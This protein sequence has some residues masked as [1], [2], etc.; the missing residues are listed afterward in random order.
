MY[1]SSRLEIDWHPPVRA[2]TMRQHRTLRWFLFLVTSTSVLVL[3]QVVLG[4]VAQSLTLLSDVAHGVADVVSYGINYAME[5]RKSRSRRIEEQS[6]KSTNENEREWEVSADLWGCVLTTVMLVGA[7]VFSLVESLDR[8]YHAEEEE[9]FDEIGSSMLVF[10]IASTVVNVGS[11]V[12]FRFLDWRDRN[13]T[14]EERAEQVAEIPQPG[15]E[16]QVEGV[17]MMECSPCDSWYG[18]A[19][20]VLH[21]GCALGSCDTVL[22]S[23]PTSTTGPRVIGVTLAEEAFAHSAASTTTSSEEGTPQTALDPSFINGGFNLNVDSAMLHLITDVLRSIT[24]VVVAVGIEFKCLK[25]AG[26]ADAICSLFV[27]FLIL[28]GAC[29]IWRRMLSLLHQGRVFSTPVEQGSSMQTLGGLA[30][31]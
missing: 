20:L 26:R 28:V 10:A 6:F 29:S 22:T 8:L 30:L 24:I 31:S 5:R 9:D 18:V 3:L 4:V 17:N 25:N 1:A 27:S 23:A 13:Q 7:T 15:T 2:V 12:I 11:L 21:P 16:A 14:R 19:H